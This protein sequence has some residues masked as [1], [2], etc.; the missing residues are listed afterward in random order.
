MPTPMCSLSFGENYWPSDTE[1][2]HSLGCP[3][4]PFGAQVSASAAHICGP[5]SGFCSGAPPPATGISTISQRNDQLY[6]VFMTV[7]LLLAGNFVLICAY[8]W[9]TINMDPRVFSP[10][11]LCFYFVGFL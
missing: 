9:V 3:F 1:L 5:H 10:E 2:A 11:T 8:C 6:F 7:D 4:P